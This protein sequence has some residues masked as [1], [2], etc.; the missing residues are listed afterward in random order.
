VTEALEGAG[1]EAG[2]GGVATGWIAGRG[3]GEWL[4]RAACRGS[5]RGGAGAATTTS[6]G[7]A[8]DAAIP[9]LRSGAGAAS[10]PS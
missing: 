2:A 10:L 7:G 3:T 5:T 6:G 8:C 4:G 1:A 9:A